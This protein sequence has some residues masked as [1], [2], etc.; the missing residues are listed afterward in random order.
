MYSGFPNYIPN[1]YYWNINFTMLY[2]YVRNFCH[3]IGWEQTYFSLIEIP[4]CKNYS[5]YGNQNRQIIS[6]H[7]LRKMAERFLDFEITRFKD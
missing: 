2:Y 1:Y 6:S 5:Y 7:E 3:L 4:T